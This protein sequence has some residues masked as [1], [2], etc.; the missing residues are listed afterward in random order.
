LTFKPDQPVVVT[1]I[2]GGGLGPTQHRP[3]R[4]PKIDIWVAIVIGP[5]PLGN[6]LWLVRKW[7]KRGKGGGVYTVPGSEMRGAPSNGNG[8][9]RQQPV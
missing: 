6:D 9:K 4:Q 8:A 3:D 5:S 7:G 1:T 2:D